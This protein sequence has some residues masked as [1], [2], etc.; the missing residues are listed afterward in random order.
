MIPKLYPQYPKKHSKTGFTLVEIIIVV[1][2]L[3]VIVSLA[4]SN[5]TTVVRRSECSAVKQ[6]LRNLYNREI[7]LQLTGKDINPVTPATLP[8]RLNNFVNQVGRA[9]PAPG[10]T[11]SRGWDIRGTYYNCF[12]NVT[13]INSCQI[14]PLNDDNPY[15]NAA[16]DPYCK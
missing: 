13:V 6:E 12:V 16:S 2:T 4:L 5:Y 1:I 3:G 15:C 11:A 7:L 8:F 10:C 14:L 9:E